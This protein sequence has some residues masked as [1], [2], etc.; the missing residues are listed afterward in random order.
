M[1]DKVFDLMEKMYSEMQNGFKEVREEISGVKQDVD[2]IKIDMN[3]LK[4]E[5]NGVKQEVG[6]LKLDIM[7]LEDKMD[8][9]F[10]ALYDGYKQNT[11][12]LH[13]LEVKVDDLSDKVKGQELEIRVIKDAK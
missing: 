7:R 3:D 2:G 5:V 1:G 11:E 4:Q 6:G 13:D 10:S 9:H 12:K 8:I